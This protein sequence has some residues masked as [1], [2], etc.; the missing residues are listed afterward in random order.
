MGKISLRKYLLNCFLL[1][2]PIF[3]WNIIFY[4]Y[5]PSAYQ[6]EISWKDIPKLLIYSENILR[7][8]VFGLPAI[9]IFSLKTRLA[10]NGLRIYSFGVPVYFLSW[11]LVIVY[12]N[13]IWSTSIIGFLAPAYTTIIWFIGIGLIGNKA[14]FKFPN[15]AKIYIGFSVIFVIIHTLH[16]NIVFQR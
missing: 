4:K 8:I 6:E 2:L 9:M 10:K 13:S 7:I 5:L 11:I 16:V 15:L 3:L 1:L 14:F 12:P